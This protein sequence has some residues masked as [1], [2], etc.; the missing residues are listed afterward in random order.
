MRTDSEYRLSNFGYMY[1]LHADGPYGPK[2]VVITRS[3]PPYI[4][5]KNP[6]VVTD[7]Y[8]HIFV[9][10]NRLLGMRKNKWQIDVT[11]K[12]REIASDGA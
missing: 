2:H 5:N 8:F 11:M 3:L 10:D 9:E 7:G 12:L 6:L 4:S 1:Q